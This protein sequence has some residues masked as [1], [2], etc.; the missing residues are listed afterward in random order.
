MKQLK[1]W[2]KSLSA[3]HIWN[4][5][6]LS[7]VLNIMYKPCFLLCLVLRFLQCMIK[8]ASCVI[9]LP[10]R[11]FPSP[12]ALIMVL[13]IHHINLNLYDIPLI[14]FFF[15]ACCVLVSSC[16]LPTFLAQL[17]LRLS[18]PGHVFTYSQQFAFLVLRESCETIWLP[19]VPAVD[20]FSGYYVYFLSHS[21]YVIIYFYKISVKTNVIYSYL[22]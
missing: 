5:Y 1:S 13:N 20:T 17:E 4:I 16:S 21:L 22:Q 7:H 14:I 6:I 12:P 9:L 10:F 11:V 8:V 3:V 2:S 19:L 18:L 15:F